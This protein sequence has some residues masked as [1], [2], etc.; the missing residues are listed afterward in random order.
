[1]ERYEYK[2]SSTFGQFYFYSHGPKGRIRKVVFYRQMA[3]L[4]GFHYYNVGFGDFDPKSG[5]INDLVVTDNKDREKVLATVVAT[6]M[7][8]TRSGRKFILIVR[9]STPARTRLYQM[10]ISLYHDNISQLFEIEGETG[11]SWEKFERGKNY[12][13][14]R[15]KRIK[16]DI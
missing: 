9:G 6:A 1:M 15:F 11:S 3:T 7:D 2:K 13:G 4:N 8:F 14:F 10:K 12:S 5:K 16:F